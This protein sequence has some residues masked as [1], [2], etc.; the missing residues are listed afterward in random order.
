MRETS[1]LTIPFVSVC[2]LL[3]KFILDFSES[4]V[5]QSKRNKYLDYITS[6]SKVKDKELE[7]IIDS[8]EGFKSSESKEI[9]DSKD[10]FKSL[11][12]KF[13]TI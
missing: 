11:N 2:K 3:N 9:I 10:E 1:S 7:I 6:S 8:T 5:T 12:S 13:S 4:N